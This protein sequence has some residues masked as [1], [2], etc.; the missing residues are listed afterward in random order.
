MKAGNDLLL[1]PRNLKRELNGVLEAV[2]SG[3][4]SEKEITEKCRKVL[5]YKYALGLKTKPH[6]QIS[7]L[8]KRLNRT[9]VAEL[10]S[11]LQKAAITVVNNTGGVLPLDAK[12]RGTTVLNIGKPSSGLE[13]YS[14]LNSIYL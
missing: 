7:G 3:W 2:K 8:D 5:T 1:A 11:R 9:E 12:L 4:L 6:V 14:R 10:I 13:F